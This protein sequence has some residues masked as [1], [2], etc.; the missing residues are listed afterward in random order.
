VP[1]DTRL[2]GAQGVELILRIEFCD[3][4]IGLD[5][6]ADVDGSLDHAS[7]DTKGQACLVLGLDASRQCD[8]LADLAFGDRYG[9]N[10]TNL[11]RRNFGVRP[12]GRKENRRR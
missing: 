7:A 3:D 4:L 10:R 5:P 9:P 12:A 8:R 6:V 2:C 1:R 11:R